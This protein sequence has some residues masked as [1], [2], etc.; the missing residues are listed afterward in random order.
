M[1]FTKILVEEKKNTF[2]HGKGSKKGNLDNWG[3]FSI[4][5]QAGH[6]V[7]GQQSLG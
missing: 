2:Y 7:V 6:V 1:H 5:F 3:R 4:N